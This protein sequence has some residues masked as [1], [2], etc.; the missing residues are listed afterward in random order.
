MEEE[1][2]ILKPQEEEIKTNESYAAKHVLNLLRAF[3]GCTDVKLNFMVPI[4]VWF[5][6][7]KKWP[8]SREPSR[9]RN[10]LWRQFSYKI[11]SS[12]YFCKNLILG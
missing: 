6:S 12:F 8:K 11:T 2:F 1:C 9:Y 5:M 3:W 4:L 10:T 7:I